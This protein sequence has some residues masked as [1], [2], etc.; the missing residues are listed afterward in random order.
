MH[1]AASGALVTLKC[2]EVELVNKAKILHVVIIYMPGWIRR[3]YKPPI[4]LIWY[5]QNLIFTVKLQ[6]A[7]TIYNR[8]MLISLQFLDNAMQCCCIPS[9]QNTHSL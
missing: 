7:A 4:E 5:I 1:L 2:R 8:K 6:L 9:A 3:N